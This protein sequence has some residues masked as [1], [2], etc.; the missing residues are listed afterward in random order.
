MM[1]CNHS[2]FHQIRALLQLVSYICIC[3]P[4]VTLYRYDVDP[5][6]FG[7]LT[8]NHPLCLHHRLLQVKYDIF[9]DLK[10]VHNRK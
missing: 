6:G 10:R 4:S 5:S 9:T 3:E 1:Q 8:P 2:A 7:A